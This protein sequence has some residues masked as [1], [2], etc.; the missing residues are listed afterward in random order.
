AG[1]KATRELEFYRPESTAV[2]MRQGPK[3]IDP[4]AGHEVG[5]EASEGF[6]GGDRNRETRLEGDPLFREGER[7]EVLRIE[8]LRDN[9][10]VGEEVGETQES[11][12]RPV[13]EVLRLRH[14]LPLESCDAEDID[15]THCVELHHS[16]QGDDRFVEEVRRS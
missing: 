15:P 10:T 3:L 6:R 16:K 7:D 1:C 2:Q 4:M 13:R 5:T 8:V 11:R 14:G 9:R 12:P